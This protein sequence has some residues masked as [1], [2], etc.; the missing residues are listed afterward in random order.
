MT[1]ISTRQFATVKRTAMN[2]YP[3]VDQIN[4]KRAEINK[5]YAEIEDLNN[6]VTSWEGGIMAMTGGYTSSDLVIKTVTIATNEDGSTKF[7][8]NGKPV[9]VTKWE[10]SNNVVWN[11]EKKVYEITVPKDTDSVEESANY[12]ENYYGN[13]NV[14]SES[15]LPLNVLE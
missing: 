10:A 11:E 1:T 8:K 13:D 9:M 14:N 6:Q 15:Q 4:K 12:D 5:L 7:D 2:V 3:L